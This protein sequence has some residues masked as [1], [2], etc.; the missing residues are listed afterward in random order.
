MCFRQGN[1]PNSSGTQHRRY[2]VLTTRPSMGVA[3]LP[4]LAPFPVPS[5]AAIWLLPSL[6]LIG[7]P[8]ASMVA[9][10]WLKMVVVS[11]LAMW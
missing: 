4:E 5:V 10:T 8:R 2:W 3:G 11:V 7:L 1:A 6:V 9:Q